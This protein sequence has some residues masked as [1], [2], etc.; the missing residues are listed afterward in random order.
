MKNLNS[1][2]MVVLLLS[3]CSAQQRQDAKKGTVDPKTKTEKVDPNQKVA[4]K[5]DPK[6]EDPKKEDPKTA[7]ASACK[8]L[9]LSGAW[10][11]N[12]KGQTFGQFKVRKGEP[13]YQAVLV[14]TGGSEGKEKIKLQLNQE[15]CILT[16]AKLGADSKAEEN[17]YYK[18]APK[19]DDASK[20][21]SVGMTPCSDATCGQLLYD[22][23]IELVAAKEKA[24]PET[25]GTA[26]NNQTSKSEILDCSKIDF[27]GKWSQVLAKTGSLCG[28]EPTNEMQLSVKNASDPSL[29]QELQE[30]HSPGI[31][32]S[33]MQYVWDFKI[34]SK[35]CIVTEVQLKKHQIL[36]SSEKDLQVDSEPSYSKVVAYEEKDGKKSLKFVPCD[37]QACA[38]MNASDPFEFIQSN[39]K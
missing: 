38:K 17:K 3:A 6:N 8:D 39:A 29:Y 12:V 16:S 10:D 32:L 28:G 1:L 20:L 14:P 25:T 37:D 34:D 2:L 7:E 22:Q 4:P 13:E 9:D 31:M 15:T 23:S 24:A 19:K 27:S 21:I 18:L 30:S 11:A 5:E 33:V 35:S 26:E 36:G